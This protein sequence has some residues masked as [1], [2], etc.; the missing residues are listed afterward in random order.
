MDDARAMDEGHGFQKAW[1]EE[2]WFDQRFTEELHLSF[3]VF[4]CLAFCF[5][6]KYLALCLCESVVSPATPTVDLLRL[7][8]VCS[9]QILKLAVKIEQF[10]PAEKF[11]YRKIFCH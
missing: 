2:L 10:L 11:P 8:I 7:N 4:D 1:R 3:F 9:V 6:W 5:F